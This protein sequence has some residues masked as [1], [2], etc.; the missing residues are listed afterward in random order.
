[1]SSTIVSTSPSKHVFIAYLDMNGTTMAEDKAGGIDADAAVNK[2]LAETTFDKWDGAISQS[3][4]SF[5]DDLFKGQPDAKSHSRELTKNFVAHLED[6]AHPLAADVSKSYHAMSEKLRNCVFPSVIKFIQ[7]M[8]LASHVSV[9]PFE[10]HIV[11]RSFGCDH[12][13]F[14][15]AVEQQTSV[16][17]NSEHVAFVDGALQTSQG[18]INPQFEPKRM[19]DF[20]VAAGHLVVQD[21]YRWWQDHGEVGSGKPIPVDFSGEILGAF[22]DDNLVLHSKT[23]SESA[24]KNIIVAYNVEDGAIVPV[25]DLILEHKR[26]I[27]VDTRAAVEDDD[28]FIKKANETM[29][30][31][32]WDLQLPVG[33]VAPVY[34][35]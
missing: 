30:R 8:E 33:A 29:Q 5:A 4:R 9:T 34:F 19:Q 35:K 12:Q 25:R 23:A 16:R 6:I 11:I 15:D 28:Y 31:A 26:A 20:V 1:M 24:N 27:I 14:I 22:F 10:F 32:G 18:P 17:F 13:K 2:L 7:A 3:Y 21:N